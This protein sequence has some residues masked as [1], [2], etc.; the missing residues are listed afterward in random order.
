M[1]LLFVCWHRTQEASRFSSLLHCALALLWYCTVVLLNCCAVVLLYCWTVALLCICTVVL[2]YCCTIVLLHCYT[3]TTY[4]AE[5]ETLNGTCL[6]NDATWWSIYNVLLNSV[7]LAAT[8]LV[9]TIALIAL[10]VFGGEMWCGA[11]WCS[12]ALS[13]GWARGLQAACG[14]SA[15]QPSWKRPKLVI[16]FWEKIGRPWGKN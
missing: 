6:Q 13:C 5:A 7:Q 15:T 11:M 1:P 10:D 9:H 8:Q 4:A 14:S 3:A 12:H 2:L 16:S